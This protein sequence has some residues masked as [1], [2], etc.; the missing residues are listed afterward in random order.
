MPEM[1]QFDYLMILFIFLIFVVTNIMAWRPD[2]KENNDC[3]TFYCATWI[4]TCIKF[5]CYCI[6]PWG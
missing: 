5:K 6:R 1:I 2:C 4:N 3:P